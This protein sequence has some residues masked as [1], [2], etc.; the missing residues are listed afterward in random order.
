MAF[1]STPPSEVEDGVWILSP[2]RVAIPSWFGD[3]DGSSAD[4]R[5][6]AWANENT[7]LRQLPENL[8][9]DNL[10]IPVGPVSSIVFGE[11]NATVAAFKGRGAAKPQSR[12]RWTDGND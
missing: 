4:L 9:K 10:P 7:E 2:K 8:V 11:R 1:Q 5:K 3:V 12:N 6:Y